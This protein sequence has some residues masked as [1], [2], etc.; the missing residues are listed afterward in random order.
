MRIV[1]TP[2]RSAQWLPIVGLVAICLGLAP[3]S[4]ATPFLSSAS[5]NPGDIVTLTFT[6]DDPSAFPME[7][8]VFDLYFTLPP[9]FPVDLRVP[10]DLQGPAF[11]PQILGVAQGDVPPYTVLTI[12]LSLWEPET[13]ELKIDIDFGIAPDAKPGNYAVEIGCVTDICVGASV[14]FD[15]FPPEGAKGF[16]T[17][18][19]RSVPEPSSLALLALGMA[20]TLRARRRAQ[21]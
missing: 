3:K 15:Y 21:P 20:G 7:G 13:T 9:L 10:S 16:I 8:L 19:A 1:N 2:T 14:D 6:E 4:Y 12:I 11:P 18:N 17:V 5:G